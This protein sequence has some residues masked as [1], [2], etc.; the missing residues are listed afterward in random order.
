MDAQRVKRLAL[1]VLFPEQC[2]GCGRVIPPCTDFCAPC[3]KGLQR[4]LP[5]V[6]P[7]CGHH[8]ESCTCRR[9]RRHYDRCAA[10]FLYDGT[11]RKALLRLKEEGR[12]DVVPLLAGEMAAVVRREYGGQVFDGIVPVP[13]TSAVLRERGFN[14]SALLAKGLARE[15]GVPLLPALTKTAET[16]PQK[17]LPAAYRSGNVLGVFDVVGDMALEGTCLLLV[18]DIVTTGSTLDECAK[19]LKIGGAASVFVITAAATLLG[20]REEKG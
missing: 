13:V 6:C 10:P 4:I 12:T 18:D 19:M 8:R 7:F 14:Q 9:R 16:K 11:A 5:P 2:A 3:R 1:S 17:E 15:L 20:R